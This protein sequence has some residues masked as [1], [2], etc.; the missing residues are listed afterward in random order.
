MRRS[1]RE[2]FDRSFLLVLGGSMGTS[3]K[4][5]WKRAIEPHWL[6]PSILG[7]D[8][9]GARENIVPSLLLCD[10]SQ[11]IIAQE[12]W[13][14]RYKIAQVRPIYCPRLGAPPVFSSTIF[15]LTAVFPHV[16]I[17]LL[18]NTITIAAGNRYEIRKS[19]TP[20]R[21]PESE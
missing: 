12:K 4:T 3:E 16:A 17:R 9:D 2:R 10:Q 7:F 5:L 19:G 1:E 8:S 11:S 20:C 21:K 6:W 13:E 18:Q 14:H 15:A